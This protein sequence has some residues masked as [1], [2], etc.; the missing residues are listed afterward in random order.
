MLSLRK[1]VLGIFSIIF[2]I[3]VG[4]SYL[5]NQNIAIKEAKQK[6]QEVNFALKMGLLPALNEENIHFFA[7]GMGVD[8]FVQKK[9]NFFSSIQEVKNQPKFDPLPVFKNGFLYQGFENQEGYY[10]LGYEV[11]QDFFNPFLFA[12]L[13]LCVFVFLW[14][15]SVVLQNHFRYFLLSIRNE[16][17]LLSAT[18]FKEVSFFG[19][20]LERMR[21]IIL[22][23]EL[24]NIKQAKKIQLKNAQLLNLVSA[25]A[26]EIKNPLSVISLALESLEDQKLESREKLIA[27]IWHQVYKLNAITQKLNFVFNLKRDSLNLEVFD[28]FALCKE[29]VE[30]YR[31]PRLQVFGEETFVNADIFLIEQ[32]M[33][34]LMS[35]ALKY[36]QGNV[37]I[38]VKNR[39]FKITDY[40]VGIAQ[41][42]YKKITKKFYKVYP[43][44][45]NS[46]GLGL[47]I[48]K[49][50]LGFHKTSLKIKSIPQK[51][52][53][54]SF[55][56]TSNLGA[57]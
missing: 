12:S 25:I 44:Q 22:N 23:K 15:L 34:N 19:R 52:T 26:H 32:V 49:K 38:E 6:I 11:K 20:Q 56:L 5:C 18:L 50:I 2:C 9:D 13:I 41:S 46:F 4:I 43:E 31:E 47:F 29:V 24:K 3:F 42:E 7:E 54:F 8:I 10:V 30:H 33:I 28:L 48:V 39:E 45:E 35:N 37:M 36:S 17:K 16:K 14:I 1:V 27:R 53:T 40:G 57:L 55:S 51:K 21:K